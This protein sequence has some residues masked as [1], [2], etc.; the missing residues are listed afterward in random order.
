MCYGAGM[1]KFSADEDEVTG[2]HTGFV[3]LFNSIEEVFCSSP[4]ISTSSIL[5]ISWRSRVITWQLN[6][7]LLKWLSCQ[8][9]LLQHDK[10][11]CTVVIIIVIQPYVLC[12]YVLTLSCTNI[13]VLLCISLAVFSLMFFSIYK[14]TV[15]HV[16]LFP[17]IFVLCLG[18]CITPSCPQAS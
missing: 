9:S 10:E 18:T 11:T 12:S 8:T 14:P 1:M 7:Q 3:N 5:L 15:E 16:D 4:V 6:V 13:V 2:F 17:R